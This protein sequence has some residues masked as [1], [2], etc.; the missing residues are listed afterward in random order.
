[1]QMQEKYHHMVSLGVANSRPVTAFFASTAMINKSTV[2]GWS[3]SQGNHVAYVCLVYSRITDHII[4]T[5]YCYP[6]VIKIATKLGIS[7]H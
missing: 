4:V 6:T 2:G 7:V 1:M 3:F 5:V